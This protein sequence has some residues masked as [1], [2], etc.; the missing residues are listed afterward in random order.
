MDIEFPSHY[1][2]GEIESFEQLK[3][4][5]DGGANELNWLFIGTSG[6]HGS[7]AKLEEWPEKTDFTVLV[8]RPRLVSCLYGHVDIEKQEQYNWLRENV[9][10]TVDVIED[11]QNTFTDAEN[12]D[13]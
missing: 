5:L 13:E 7:Y 12:T 8:V 4:A 9:K 1:E 11:T 6:V 2:N 3:V 10:K